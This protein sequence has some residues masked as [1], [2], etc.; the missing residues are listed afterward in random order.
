MLRLAFEEYWR[1]QSMVHPH[2]P[3]PRTR[4][5]LT[6]LWH[7]DAQHRSSPRF[8]HYFLLWP[9]SLF[10]HCY[11]FPSSSWSLVP[12]LAK[13]FW[14]CAFPPLSSVLFTEASYFILSALLSDFFPSREIKGFSRCLIR[15]L[16]KI[17]NKDTQLFIYNFLCVWLK[18]R[19]NHRQMR[20]V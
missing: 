8:L 13:A 14:T 10:S 4:E 6:L 9:L 3:L 5:C 7:C 1:S 19:L 20:Q 17:K 16:K 15:V 18:F 11:P 2:S 12:T